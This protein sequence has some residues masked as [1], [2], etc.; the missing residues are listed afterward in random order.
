[1]NIKKYIY[2]YL[3]KNVLLLYKKVILLELLDKMIHGILKI[4]TL[5]QSYQMM[6]TN[7]T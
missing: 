2:I 1:M 5:I 3:K 4:Q 7:N 6:Y